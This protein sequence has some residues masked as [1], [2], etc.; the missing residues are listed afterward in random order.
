MISKLFRVLLVGLMTLFLSGQAFAWENSQRDKDINKNPDQDKSF[1]YNQNDT[2]QAMPSD[3]DLQE[4]QQR[5]NQDKDF[6]SSSQDFNNSQNLDQST[7]KT[8]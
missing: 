7:S 3:K 5:M 2:D 4:N 6:N 8:Y 1:M